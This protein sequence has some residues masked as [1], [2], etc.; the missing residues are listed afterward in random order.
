M[1]SLIRNVRTTMRCGQ[2]NDLRNTLKRQDTSFLQVYKP[3][4]KLITPKNGSYK[5]L[6]IHEEELFQLYYIKWNSNSVSGIHGHPHQKCFFKIL[7]G[8]LQEYVYPTYIDSCNL[9]SKHTYT[10]G[11]VSFIDDTIGFHNIMNNN[12]RDAYSLHLY[13]K[14]DHKFLKPKFNHLHS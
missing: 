10:P 8:S 11:Y 7:E 5:K 3:D 9:H 2:L 13:F 4:F 1:N 14:N 12:E 6:S